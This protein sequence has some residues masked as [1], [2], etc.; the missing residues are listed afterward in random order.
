MSILVGNWVA[1]N[2]DRRI[3]A[4][5]RWREKNREAYLKGKAARY[6][7]DP[8]K[9]RMLAIEYRASPKGQRMKEN[10]RPRKLA[11]LAAWKKANP[12][13]VRA[14][15]HRRRARELGIAGDCSAHDVAD[16]ARRQE[17]RCAWCKERLPKRGYHLDHVFP[18]KLGGTNDRSNLQ[19]LCRNCNC[20]KG[21]KHPLEFARLEGRLL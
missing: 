3:A 1:A 7:A 17:Y 13:R 18:L 6:A 9:M 21:A 5:D 10:Y 20:R 4:T 2:K 8:E 16:L 14:T 15:R 19:L 12:D 11:L